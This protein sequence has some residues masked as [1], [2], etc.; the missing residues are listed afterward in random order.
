MWPMRLIKPALFLIL[1]CFST[2]STVHADSLSGCEEHVKY[3]APSLNPDLLCRPGYALSHNPDH[4]VPD[5]VAY[6]LTEDK[7]TGT[8]PHSDNY[9]PDPDLAP[10]KRSELKD[11]KGRGFV[12]GQMAPA[13][14]MKWDERAMSAS[15]LLSNIAPQAGEG[16]NRGIWKTLEGKVREWVSARGELYVVTGPIYFTEFHQHIGSNNVA[17]PTHFYKVLFDPV[18]VE[19]IAFVLPNKKLDS[20]DLSNYI[21]SVDR[22]EAQ[23]GLNF[24]SK[25]DDSVESL[26]ESRVEPVAWQLTATPQR[27]DIIVIPKRVQSIDTF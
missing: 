17:V 12:L 16:F 26:V 18:Q 3:G 8:V 13:E 4:K 2:A 1:A 24:L 25:L 6:H 27:S 9:R 15:F 21:V 5:W 19:A 22:A 14:D 10:G 11:Y 20:Q 7:T 23:T